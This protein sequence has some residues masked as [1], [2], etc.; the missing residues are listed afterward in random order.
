MPH[1]RPDLDTGIECVLTFS[2]QRS[3]LGDPN[4]NETH[5]IRDFQRWMQDESTAMLTKIDDEKTHHDPHYYVPNGIKL[6]PE[7]VFYKL[8]FFAPG[9]PVH[10]TNDRVLQ[11]RDIA[12]VRS[13]QGRLGDQFDNHR[14]LVVW[15]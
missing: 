9:I 7:Y 14:K 5:D 3:L 8:F 1:W 11:A 13:G 15:Q 4:F 10:I 6:G 12:Y 2:L